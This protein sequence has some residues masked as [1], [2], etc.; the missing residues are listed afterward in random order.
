VT[1]PETP[2]R[3]RGGLAGRLAGR[4]KQAAGSL[5]GDK[6][7]ARE[8]RLQEAHVDAEADA[9][10]AAQRAR[11]ADAGVAL[12]AARTENEIERERLENDVSARE[13]EEAIARDRVKA[14]QAAQVEAGRREAAADAQRRAQQSAAQAAERSAEQERLAAA[15]EAAALEREARRAEA[16]AEAIDPEER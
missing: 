1:N 15:Q 12:D 6:D 14:E 5:L 16:T 11:Q 10:A 3:T 13:R 9:E 8:G 2:E 4:F 7:L